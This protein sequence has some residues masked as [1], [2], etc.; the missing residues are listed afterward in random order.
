MALGNRFALFPALLLLGCTLYFCPTGALAARPESHQCCH[1]S[2]GEPER[3]E[4]SD[5]CPN[6]WFLGKASV[7]IEVDW[8]PVSFAV[9]HAPTLPSPHWELPAATAEDPPRYVRLRVFR[10]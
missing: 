10:L 6:Q 9:S 4:P 3:V 7:E 5:S 8:V 1:R 2:H